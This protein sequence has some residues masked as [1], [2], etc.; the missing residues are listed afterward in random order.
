MGFSGDAKA[1]VLPIHGVC[2]HWPN[3]SDGNYG[4]ER[5]LRR[6]NWK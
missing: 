1:S 2:F 6:K 5:E 3:R 4:K